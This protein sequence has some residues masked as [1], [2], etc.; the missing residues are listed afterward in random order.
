[1]NRWVCVTA[2]IL[3]GCSGKEELK[4]DL[5][6]I[7]AY[8]TYLA[9]NEQEIDNPP[10][11]AE[12]LSVSAVGKIR[13]QPDLAVITA[14]ISHIDKNESRAVDN[15]AAQINAL[16]SAFEGKDIELGFT[17]IRSAREFDEACRFANQA[18]RTRHREVQQDY[19]FNKRLN[20]R[21]DTETKRRDPKPRLRET[22]CAAQEIKI[23]SDVVIRVKPASEAG[24]VLNILAQNN[25]ESSNL[26]GYDFS[27]FDAL[28]QQAADK[29]VKLARKKADIV[30]R[31]AGASLG[32]IKHFSVSR[33]NRIGRFG[34]QPTI[35]RPQRPP[36]NLHGSVIDRYKN[37][38]LNNR[39]F[40]GSSLPPGDSLP[41]ESFQRCPD[42]S[43]IPSKQVCNSSVLTSSFTS[44]SSAY[45]NE[46][47]VIQEASSE[48]IPTPPVYE[49][50]YDN[51]IARRVIKQPAS[52]Q[53]RV[54]PAVVKKRS[55]LFIGEGGNTNALSMSLFSG[56]QTISVTASLSYQYDTPMSGKIIIHPE[57]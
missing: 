13:A 4:L 50:I 7:D 12:P 28:Y 46:L 16:Q 39:R 10:F 15:V 18:A 11:E 48:L 34:P 30:A 43:W 51:G 57:K 52:S 53:E 55:E 40:R 9:A 49:T 41:G 29:A 8:K 56:P 42:G 38:R 6:E 25:I 1:M 37:I 47:I 32:E 26:F 35:I 27:D 14:R 21:G 22:I 5:G 19:W 33:P 20:D 23:S 45:D 3:A 31:G 2:L 24:E 54:I 44:S 17:A 36:E